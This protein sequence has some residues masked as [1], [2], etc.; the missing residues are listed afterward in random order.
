MKLIKQK[1]YLPIKIK[2]ELPKEFDIVTFIALVPVINQFPKLAS[3][4][5]IEFCFNGWREDDRF[6]LHG[7]GEELAEGKVTHWLKEQ[8]GYFF[9]SE[10]LNQLL[11]DVIKDALDTAA[12]KAKINYTEDGE[13]TKV[14]SKKLDIDCLSELGANVSFKLNK[15]SITKTLTE[16]F[17]KFK[18]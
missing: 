8:E 7:L 11:S 9:T 15:E 17:N 12:E 5:E 2:D 4:T 3:E 16:T 14:K 6:L 10:Q 1:I 18:V 13:I